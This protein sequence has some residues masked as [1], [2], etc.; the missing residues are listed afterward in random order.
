MGQLS[1][2]YPNYKQ[3]NRKR[4]IY[5]LLHCSILTVLHL[6]EGGVQKV[7]KFQ[8]FVGL[9]CNGPQANGKKKILHESTKNKNRATQM[10]G[11]LGQLYNVAGERKNK[12]DKSN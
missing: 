2:I 8:S 3:L 9:N 11:N 7:K 5:F 6:Q 12:E 4:G 10:H 1:F